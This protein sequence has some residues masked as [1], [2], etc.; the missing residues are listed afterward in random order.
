MNYKLVAID[1]DGTLL[2]NENQVPPR[3]KEVIARLADQGVQ[4]VL[5]SGRP[6]QSLHPYTDELEVYLP[7]ITANGSIV[8]CS[9][10]DKVYHKV[11][12]PLDLAQEVLDYGLA[13]DYGVSLYFEDEI[14]TC[15]QEM[16][17]GHQELE[18]VEPIIFD[19][20]LEL[21]TAPVKIIYYDQPAEITTAFSELSKKYQDKLYITRSDDHYV[22][23]MNLKV[24]KGQ[25]LEY[26]MEQMNLSSQEVIA[27]GNNHN[28]VAMFE[29]AGLAVAMEN[30]PEEVKD[31][32][33]FVTTSNQECGV[34]DALEKFI[35]N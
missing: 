9:I 8:K 25:A 21:E 27:I 19:C 6:Y 2:N 26:L 13:N 32:A 17:A 14:Y 35:I 24:S 23:A 18:G 28:D 20:D 34:A 12:L 3:N 31:Q 1:M 5:A 30:A 33:D 22:E 29:T 4:F 15:D 11:Q 7:L 10:T 16:A